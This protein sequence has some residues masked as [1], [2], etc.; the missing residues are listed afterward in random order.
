MNKP[1]KALEETWAAKER[2]YQ[3]NAGK[4]MREIIESVEHKSFKKEKLASA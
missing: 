4:S 3:I 2:F 1:S